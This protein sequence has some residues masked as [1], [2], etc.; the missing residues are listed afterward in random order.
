MQV[1]LWPCLNVHLLRLV[2]DLVLV[3]T[4][5]TWKVSKM[6]VPVSIPGGPDLSGSKAW[7][8][9]F[10]MLSRWFNGQAAWRVLVLL[11][12]LLA[13]CYIFLMPSDPYNLFFR[14]WCDNFIV[15]HGVSCSPLEDPRPSGVAQEPAAAASPASLSQMHMQHPWLPERESA[16]HRDPPVVCCPKV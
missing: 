15:A 10:L 7:A 5:V 3:F 2:L 13:L 6:L 4:S 8:M 16:F 9:C 12:L 11:F 14:F 1:Y